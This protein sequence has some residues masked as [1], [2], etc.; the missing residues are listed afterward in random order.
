M[1]FYNHKKTLSTHLSFLSILFSTLGDA[2]FHHGYTHTTMLTKWANTYFRDGRSTHARRARGGNDRNR[3]ATSCSDLFSDLKSDL[4]LR[5]KLSFYL[6]YILTIITTKK[7]QNGPCTSGYTFSHMISH[8][9]QA[10]VSY[11]TPVLLN[12]EK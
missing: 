6:Y 3:V 11:E 5:R 2:K 1:F 10:S 8:T 4:R 9:R 7:T 12:P